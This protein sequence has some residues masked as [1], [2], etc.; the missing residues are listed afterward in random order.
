MQTSCEAA[1]QGHTLFLVMV[2]GLQQCLV[3]V[4]AVEATAEAEQ[5]LLMYMPTLES[6]GQTI[7]PITNYMVVLAGN[8]VVHEN[9]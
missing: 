8:W 2:C 6:H 4:Q 1:V 5:Q 3:T 9:S 7:H